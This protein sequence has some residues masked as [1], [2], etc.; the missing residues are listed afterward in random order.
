ML[1][2]LRFTVVLAAVGCASTP[3][4]TPAPTASSSP[5]VGAL[6]ITRGGAEEHWSTSVAAGDP[7]PVTEADPIAGA[8]S[9]PVT[10]VVFGDAT[11][12]SCARELQK[13]DALRDAYGPDKLRVAW[14]H[15]PA[16]TSAS[17]KDAAAL[18]AA[19]F[20][21][22]GSPAF[23]AFA[24]SVA[25]R[26]MADPKADLADV[27][28]AGAEAARAE[29]PFKPSEL[30]ERMGAV[31]PKLEEDAALA[32][33][34][35]VKTLPT[36]F[37][38][39]I[40]LTST[41]PPELWKRLVDAEL[42]ATA[43]AV[44]SGN[45]STVYAER[46]GF[47]TRAGFG[48]PTAEVRTRNPPDETIY[49]AV[50]GA[51]P[52]RG[53]A[54]ALVT[55]VEF[56]DFEENYS[57][58][59]QDELSRLRTFYGDKVRL[60][61]KFAPQPRHERG[62]LAAE[63]AAYI[64]DKKGEAAF[65][66][67]HDALFGAS[68]A[69]DD[70]TLER[71]AKD[72]GLDA[73]STVAA[74]KAHKHAALLDAD[75]DLADDLKVGSLPQIFINGKRLKGLQQEGYIAAMIDAE[76]AG[77]EQR[78]ARGVQASGVYAAIMADAK[79]MQAF[80]TRAAP[81]VTK[82]NPAKGPAGAAITV[83]VFCEYPS[84][85]CKKVWSTLGELDKANPNELRFV[86]RS[87]PIAGTQNAMPSAIAGAEVR[88]QKGDATFWK[89]T[90]EIFASKDRDVLGRAS[91]DKLAATYGLDVKAFDAA[92]DASTP[93]P[94][95]DDDLK[96]VAELGLT[97]VPTT[98]IGDFMIVGWVPLETFQH[99]VRSARAQKKKP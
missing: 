89:W 52:A 46:L 64:F 72:A 2:S 39:G 78:V 56:G 94:V 40:R 11:H 90:D 63:L 80:Q 31:G 1:R 66:L 49:P 98:F 10:I 12:V 62:A 9:A 7:V 35:Q 32:K 86:W 55:I 8:P 53:K 59:F 34:L 93:P 45:L 74:V 47:N 58:S 81:A 24:R 54:D 43:D 57:R 96:R 85:Y 5:T 23:F 21:L 37:V 61:F 36:F 84:P 13:I 79:P 91:L 6:E 71:V 25:Q 83:Q 92:L 48:L 38:N 99:A 97:A 29:S 16:S 27:L 73:K 95:I 60:V 70:A 87:F 20:D 77:A 17:S 88:R 14:K 68:A 19:L 33:T 3:P 4:P 50:V 30:E 75:R 18:G 82:D 26:R 22:G 15:Y 41:V 51:S 28:I 76:L 69:L 42:T 65:W 44:A 67:A